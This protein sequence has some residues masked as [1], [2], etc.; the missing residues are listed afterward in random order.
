MRFFR[1][2][3]LRRFS[4]RCA[5]ERGRAFWRAAASASPSEAIDRSVSLATSARR[6]SAAT[7]PRIVSD[8]KMKVNE[9]KGSRTARCSP[10]DD[11]EDAE[12]VIQIRETKTGAINAPKESES[13][14]R[15]SFLV[16]EPFLLRQQKKCI[17]FCPETAVRCVMAT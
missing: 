10:H 15:T 17:I 3:F 11:A 2:L 6:S 12:A 1:S 14:R 7:A 5:A 16:A 4:S 13:Y 8:A 9:Q